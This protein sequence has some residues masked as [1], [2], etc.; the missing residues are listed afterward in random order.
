MCVCT[1]AIEAITDTLSHSVC[2]YPPYAPSVSPCLHLTLLIF[3]ICSSISHTHTHTPTHTHTDTQFI[4]VHFQCCCRTQNPHDTC[5]SVSDL[6]SAQG[7]AHHLCPGRTANVPPAQHLLSSWKTPRPL[8]VTLSHTPHLC[9]LHHTHL[10][11]P[12]DPYSVVLA[13]L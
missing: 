8:Q 4:T 7:S 11:R 2:S 1:Q 6:R 13:H 12:C 3:L 5:S 9:Y 10:R